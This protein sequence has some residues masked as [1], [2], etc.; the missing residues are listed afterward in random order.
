MSAAEIVCYGQTFTVTCW[1]QGAHQYFWNNQN[2]IIIETA[3][4]VGIHV[5]RSTALGSLPEELFRCNEETLNH[6]FSCITEPNRY[7]GNKM[8]F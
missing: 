2:V 3:P 5:E 8:S 7:M 6:Q 1:G 4:E